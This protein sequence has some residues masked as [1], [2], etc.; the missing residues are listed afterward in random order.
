M[1]E[2]VM[3]RGLTRR[4]C[5]TLVTTPSKLPPNATRFRLW[6]HLRD[7]I[8]VRLLYETWGR[9]GE[10]LEVEI[11]DVDFEHS[12]I[13]IAHPKGKA[14]FRIIDGKR[15]HVETVHPQRWVFFSEHTRS[16]II[17]F[18][19]G[20]RKGH[21]TINSKG[22]KL[23]K[24]EAERLVDRYAN[25][26]GIQRI[27]RH[28]KDGREIRLVTCKALREAGERHTDEDGGDRD[29]TA[30]IAGHTVRT[31]ET[32]YKR[33]NFEE[34]MNVVRSHHPLMRTEK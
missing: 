2:V 29:A 10:L 24:R 6:K 23:S 19:D 12:A 9:I 5:I 26:A 8:L 1:V 14:V 33:G 3:D 32:Y 34:D 4:E 16:L 25:M 13:R 28:A 30:R 21:L 7:E 15:V 11:K 17:R 18:L 22:K 27:V 31:K 20:R